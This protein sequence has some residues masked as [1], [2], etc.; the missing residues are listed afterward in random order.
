[1]L[2]ER[3]FVAGHLN[4]VSLPLGPKEY[5]DD[6]AYLSQRVGALRETCSKVAGWLKVLPKRFIHRPGLR[7]HSVR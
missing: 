1:M 3:S 5:A 7:L 4:C 6:S 2:A